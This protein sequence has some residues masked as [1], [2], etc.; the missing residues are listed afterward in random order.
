MRTRQLQ[1]TPWALNASTYLVI[2]AFVLAVYADLAQFSGMPKHIPVRGFIY[3]VKTGK[4][5]E[6]A[7]S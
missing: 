2:F 7:A 5:R 1:N 6:V 3:D 4:L